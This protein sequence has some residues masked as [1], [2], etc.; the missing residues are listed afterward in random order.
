MLRGIR[1]QVIA[2]FV[3]IATFALVLILR[4]NATPEPV[5]TPPAQTS[6]TA[7]AEVTQAIVPTATATP[8]PVQ[9]ATLEPLSAADESSD[10]V[11]GIVGTVDRLNPLFAALNPAEQDI[12]SLIYEGLTQ[13]NQYGEIVGDLAERWVVSRDGLEYVF[14]L[15]DDVLWQDGSAFTA[16]DVLFTVNLLSADVFPGLEAQAAFWRTVEA[17]KV[18]SYTVRFRL[19]QPLASFPGLLTLG[20]LPEHA[21][22][23]T[24]AEQLITHPF[25]LAPIGTG[26]YQLDAIR[27]SDGQTIEAVDLVAAPTYQQ[28][29]DDE[30]A[31]GYILQH[32]RFR[33]FSTFDEASQ[34]LAEGGIDGLAAVDWAQRETLLGISGLTTYTT[35]APSVGMLLFNWDEPEGVRFFSDQRVRTA[36]QIGINRTTP[37][38]SNLLNRAIVANSPLLP[39][40][41][42][43]D[44]DLAIPAADTARARELLENANIYTSDDEATEETNPSGVLYS[45]SILTLDQPEI[46]RIAQEIATQW[47]QLGLEVTVESLP[48]A[49]FQTRIEAGEFQAAIVE[50][51]LS[52]DPDIYAYWHSSQYPDGLNY[53]GAAESRIDELLER[54]RRDNNGLNRDLLYQQFQENFVSRAIAI[55]LYYPLFTYAVRDEISGVQLGFIG[56]LSDRFRTIQQWQHSADGL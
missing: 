14:I 5:P 33:I 25:N 23:G 18:D 21:L 49:D 36:L 16:D 9:A 55:P 30:G 8:E 53:G 34:A 54:G 4:M 1:W 43:Y 7:T 38:E 17:Q 26:A 32:L 51:P 2:L 31:N 28:R 46:M 44:P 6:A 20:I 11:E 10:F 12:V 3:S 15:R 22:T 50:L 13:I 48:F 52:I 40:S 39:I 24:T 19:A 27:S 37:I 56:A 29:I 41:W 47:S 35:T 42:A 45:F